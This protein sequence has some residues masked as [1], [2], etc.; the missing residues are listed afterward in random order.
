MKFHRYKLFS[1]G[2]L[3]RFSDGKSAREG[4]IFWD[5]DAFFDYHPWIEFG[6]LPVDEFLNDVRMRGPSR[7]MSK[8]FSLWRE[9]STLDYVGF[10]N[11][12]LNASG[13]VSK[14]KFR[15]GMDLPSLIKEFGCQKIRIDFNN[16][17]D[18]EETKSLWASLDTEI[19]HKIEY[20]E[21]P[22]PEIE[23]W[24]QLKQLGI[25]LACDRNTAELS[26]FDFNIYKPNVDIK[27]VEGKRNIFSSY[28]GHDLGRFQ[29]YLELMKSGDLDLYHGIDTPAIYENQLVL[30]ESDG[31][32]TFLIES[33]LNKLLD[34][35]SSYDWEEI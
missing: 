11:H 25:P 4:I 16:M 17:L 26:S 32:K 3:N 2:S 7:V 9:R 34:Q 23:Q 13:E 24:K 18:I 10:F 12:S 20:F 31:R 6:D 19:K 5:G 8:H 14:I 15:Q 30:F 29:A 27:P 22:C 28:M 33:V 21:D 1:V 35:V